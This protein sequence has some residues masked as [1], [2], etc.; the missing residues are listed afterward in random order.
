MPSL[1][2]SLVRPGDRRGRVDINRHE[3]ETIRL[4][5]ALMTDCLKR[6]IYFVTTKFQIRGF[7]VFFRPVN[8]LIG[9]V[10]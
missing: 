1:P 5:N 7:G 8:L 2:L 3:K 9:R 6:E 4:P 10:A